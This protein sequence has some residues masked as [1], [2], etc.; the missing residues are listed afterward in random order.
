MSGPSE[1]LV[2]FAYD[3]LTELM[4]ELDM[5]CESKGTKR[6]ADF[7]EFSL[8]VIMMCHPFRVT[9]DMMKSWNGNWK[10]LF[11][12]LRRGVN[13]TK[14]EE[15]SAWEGNEELLDALRAKAE[16]RMEAEMR[17]AYAW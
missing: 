8:V 14:Y 11:Q 9:E 10:L 1:E 3:L 13:G 7:I 5:T 12:A 15:M 2:D 6:G 16:W 17:E 4:D